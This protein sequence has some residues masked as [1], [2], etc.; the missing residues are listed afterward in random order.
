MARSEFDEALCFFEI[1]LKDVGVS[2][3]FQNENIRRFMP[4]KNKLKVLIWDLY[5]KDALGNDNNDNKQ[6]L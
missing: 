3:T 1:I 4:R 2:N 5:V 6:W